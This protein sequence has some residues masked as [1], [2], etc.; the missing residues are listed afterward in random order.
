MNV[1]AILPNPTG[2]SATPAASVAITVPVDDIPVT[3]IVQV[4]L[5]DVVGVPAVEPEAVPEL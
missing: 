3:G 4:I 2:S 5:S 1:E